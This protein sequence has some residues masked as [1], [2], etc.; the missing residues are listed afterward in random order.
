MYLIDGNNVMGQRPGWHRDKVAAQRR[1]L[2]EL[3]RFVRHHRTQLA[4]VF[5]GRPLDHIPDGSRTRG[6]QVFY[7]RQG[8]DADKRIIEMVE[9]ERNRR[10]L[11][12]V[13]SDSALRERVRLHGVQT[14]RSGE[15]RRMLDSLPASDSEAEPK[16]EKEQPEPWMRY[17]GIDAEDLDRS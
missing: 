6:F 5:D 2:D 10:G 7:A 12:V 14:M 8:S 15:F 16:P 11:S 3:A 17:F 1:L 9:A 4:V 13:T